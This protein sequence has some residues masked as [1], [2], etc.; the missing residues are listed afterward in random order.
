MSFLKSAGTLHS[1]KDILKLNRAA[2]VAL[3]NYHSAVLRQPSKLS[4]KQRELIAAFV[5]GLNACDYCHGVH[6]VAA[7]SFGLEEGLLAALIEDLD[8][9]M[10]E[11]ELKPI[12]RYAQI[13]T[14][15]PSKLTQAHADAVYEAGWSEQT[16]HDAINVICLFNFMNRLVEGHGL[17]GNPGLYDERGE[18]LFQHGYEPLLALLAEGKEH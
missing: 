17:K 11:E 5:S 18:A 15:N 3:V 13:L 9:A 12:L 1:V 6:S 2:G 10:V 7:R 16:L 4:E 14:Q 8:T